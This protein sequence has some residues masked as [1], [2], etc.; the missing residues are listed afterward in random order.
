MSFDGSILAI[1]CYAGKV[2]NVLVAARKL[3]EESCLSAV[4][5]AHQGK[6]KPAAAGAGL[7]FVIPGS[8]FTQ[9]RVF[10]GIVN[11]YGFYVQF[12]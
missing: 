1:D 12:H 8:V 4:L 11:V 9:T 2:T 7:A 6:G 3:V 10:Y 5:I